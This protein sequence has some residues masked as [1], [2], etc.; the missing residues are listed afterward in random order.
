M[1]KSLEVLVGAVVPTR[2]QNLL[3]CTFSFPAIEL[4]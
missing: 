2:H 1:I 3:R 4:P